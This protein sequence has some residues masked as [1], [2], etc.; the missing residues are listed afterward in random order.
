M[1]VHEGECGDYIMVNWWFEQ[2]IVHIMSMGHQ[3]DTVVICT[4]TGCR[5][6]SFVSGNWRYAGLNA[7]PE[8]KPSSAILS[9]PIWMP[10]CSED[11]MQ[12]SDQDE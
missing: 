2:D 10:T 1:I 5:E 3:K 11:S 8:S 4:I 12:M 9:I 6:Q 7:M